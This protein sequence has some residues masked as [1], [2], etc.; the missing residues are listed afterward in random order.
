M[1]RKLS[2]T[3]YMYVHVY[4]VCAHTYTQIYIN[5]I[6]AHLRITL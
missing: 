5:I 6:N 2:V 4:Y 3:W 1:I